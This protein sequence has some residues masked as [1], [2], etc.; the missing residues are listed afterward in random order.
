[1]SYCIEML[2]NHLTFVTLFS[3]P[4][5]FLEHSQS[6]S[7]AVLLVTGGRVCWLSASKPQPSVIETEQ[8]IGI[9]CSSLL[10]VIVVRAPA[11]VLAGV[12]RR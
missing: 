11:P 1:M 5:L 2:F 10:R 12:E 3:S 9:V 6:F 8:A 4:Q 7:I